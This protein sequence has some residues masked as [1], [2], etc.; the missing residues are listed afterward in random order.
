MYIETPGGLATYFPLRSGYRLPTEAEW[1]WAARAAG[2][3]ES[4][5]FAWGEDVRP[6]EDR[7][8]NLAD[9]NAAEILP[10]TLL[11]YSDG[12]PVT[13]P[14]ASFERNPVG[15]YDLGGNV[16]EW[17]QDFYEISVLPGDGVQVDPL[18]PEMGQLHVIRGPSW[19]S[20][21]LTDLRLAYRASGAEER[22]DVGFRIARNLGTEEELE[23]AE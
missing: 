20:A 18:G 19:R 14:V 10:T 1:A 8:A 11:T 23:P 17:I 5:V 7:V 21:S 3:D 22:E 16:A 4:A 6:P 13:A 12:F 15:I 2:R 9:L